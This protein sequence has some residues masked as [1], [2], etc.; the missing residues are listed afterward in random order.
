MNVN[1]FRP[2]DEAEID[3]SVLGNKLKGKIHIYFGDMAT[4]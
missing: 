3:A 1:L 2:G 4:L